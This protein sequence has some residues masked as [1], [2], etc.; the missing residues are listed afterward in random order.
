MNRE[1]SAK[2]LSVIN[3]SKIPDLVQVMD[4]LGT[5]LDPYTQTSQGYRS[6]GKAYQIPARYGKDNRESGETSVDL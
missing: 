5:K 6:I 4:N 1:D 3:L 2:T